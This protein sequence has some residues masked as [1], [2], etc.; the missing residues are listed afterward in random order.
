[1]PD[2]AAPTTATLL[3][4]NITVSLTCPVNGQTVILS[5]PNPTWDISEVQ[6]KQATQEQGEPPDQNAPRRQPRL[7]LNGYEFENALDETQSGLTLTVTHCPA[8]G[9][10][11]VLDIDDI[12]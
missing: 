1:M 2:Q 10:N 4:F 7:G 8:C 11:H 9:Q 12:W 6:A 3:A 5:T